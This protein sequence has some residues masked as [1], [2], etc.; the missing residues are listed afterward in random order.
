MYSL[1]CT[2]NRPCMGGGGLSNAKLINCDNQGETA[3][4]DLTA[5]GSSLL[6]IGFVFL[7]QGIYW[8]RPLLYLLSSYPIPT[9]PP[10]FHTETITPVLFA[11][12][13]AVKV[14]IQ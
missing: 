14:S 2:H 13:C 11:T 10:P 8:R 6:H 9:T 5:H 4:F 7:V 3:S 12:L 1:D